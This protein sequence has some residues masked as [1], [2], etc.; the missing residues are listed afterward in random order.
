MAGMGRAMER[1]EFPIPDDALAQHTAVLGKTGSGKTSTSKLL[2]EHVVAEDYRVCILDPIKS[3]WWGITS[4]EDGTSAGLPFNILG[5]PHAHAPLP[6]KAG[7]AIGQIV[8][9]GAL[10][11]SILDMADFDGGDLQRF[12][13]DFASALM[14]NMRGVLYLVIE[15]AHEFAPKERAGFGAENQ[16]IHWAK[17]LATAGRSKGI[18]LVVATQ[19]VQALHNAVLGSCETLIVHR[20]TTPADQDPA[21]NW[22]KRNADKAVQDA[23]AGSL[24][25][26]PTG[27]GWLCSGE[28]KIFERVDFPRIATFD[29]TATPDRESGQRDIAVAAVDQAAL[30]AI[31]GEAIKD[32]AASDPAVLKAE[33]TRLK[34]ELGKA[35]RSVAAPPQPVTIVANQEAVDAARDEGQR[36]GIA[37]GVA[38]ARRAID[39]IR[40]EVGEGP[41]AAP[42]QR[43]AA[44]PAAPRADAPQ[45]VIVP[46]SSGLTGPQQ[47]ILD[48]LAWWAAFG[49]EQP[50]NEQV[51]FVAGYSPTS[52]GYT[53]PRGALKTPGLIEYPAAGRV[54]MTSAGAERANAPDAPPTRDEMHRRIFGKLNG[55][56]E[57][58]LRPCVEAWPR[59]L[60]NA[61]VAGK[62][63]Y[64]P[65]STGYT[66]P[67]GSLKMLSLIEYPRAGEVRAS[68]WL[69][70]DGGNG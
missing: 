47:R 12:F 59:S 3:D 56:Q 65:T 13:S 45:L 9:S 14:R 6:P 58:I 21:L 67:R 17:K 40:F 35:Q 19:R 61:E 52:T 22:L 10:P 57:R 34:H 1:A 20:L 51:A 37:I 43:R 36:V 30:N 5:G 38:K 63:G 50:S 28:A 8:A 68:D 16:S 55:P 11:L 70:P 31:L 29:N 2:I 26:L 42:R 4:S 44:P 41:A 53:N 32:V 62:A 64:S 15:E 18:R 66:N 54:R 46:I 49:I 48:A 33:I 27:T 7:K 60:T 23:V 39:A 24:S 25:S 69:F